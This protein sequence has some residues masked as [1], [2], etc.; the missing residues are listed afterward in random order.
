MLI[1]RGST[2]EKVLFVESE[3]AAKNFHRSKTLSILNSTFLQTFSG[4][5][6]AG[7]MPAA[8]LAPAYGSWGCFRVA[9]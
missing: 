6:K 9:R 8:L 3:L 7:R 4:N 2:T 5:A 1:L